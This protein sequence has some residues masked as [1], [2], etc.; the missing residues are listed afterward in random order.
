MKYIKIQSQGVIDPQAFSLI[1]AS[2]KRADKSK[3]GF[4]GSGL[5]YSLAYLLRNNIE[6]KVFGDFVQHV[7]T[8]SPIQFR[9]NTFDAIEVNGEKTSLTTDMGID[10]DAWFI[11]REIYCNALDEGESKIS[12]S[13]KDPVPVEGQTIFYINSEPFQDIV[14]NWGLYFSEGRH[15][16]EIFYDKKG[17]KIFSGGANKIVYRK[18]IR[19]H[20]T[21]T[22][23]IFNYD[24][25]DVEINESR[26]IKSDWDFEM[27]LTRKLCMIDDV[28]IVNTLLALINERWE[29]NLRWEYSPGE[30]FNDVWLTAINN[31][32]LVPNENAGFWIDIIKESP[33]DYI[34]L[35]SKLC[36]AIKGY[37]A[38][39]VRL[40]GEESGSK[41]A[42]SI[43]VEK[44]ARMDSLIQQSL[45]FLKTAGYDVK[46]PIEVVRFLK[47]NTMG[48]ATK[49]TILLSEKV[50]D[51][52][53]KYIISTIVE[54]NEHNISGF[55]DET[56]AFQTHIFD[57]W[58][59]TMEDKTGIYL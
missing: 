23:C 19:C 4:F 9:D 52:G 3:I 16:K 18:G 24:M 14:D 7:F 6:F 57:R 13:S 37:F 21:E 40:I 41:D 20:F 38:D 22:P 25:E 8:K 29:A 50:F 15:E 5:K 26:V 39:K 55:G 59:S 45:D 10:W 34:M 27:N 28:S 56:R 58:V 35:P 47:E 46:Y 11:I 53:R 48:R 33:G 30:R 2:S 12:L 36:N 1:G 42:S 31:R 43:K 49:D 44:T 32:I 17:F 51:K 54:E